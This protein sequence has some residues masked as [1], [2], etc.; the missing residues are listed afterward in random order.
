MPIAAALPAI[1]PAVG[2]ILGGIFG[3][4]SNAINGTTQ[5]QT[6]GANIL[7]NQAAQQATAAG[8]GNDFALEQA[9][10]AR[11]L[12]GGANTDF[13]NANNYLTQAS[14]TLQQPANYYSNILSG[15]RAAMMDA[16][17]PEIQNINANFNQAQRQAGQYAPMGGGR[18]NLLAQLPLQRA[19]AVG[20][21][22]Q[23]IRPQAAQGLLGVGNAQAN[24]GGLQGNIAA[25]QGNIGA[26]LSTNTLS[27]LLSFGSGGTQTGAAL[28]NLGL[29]QSEQQNRAG[30]Q[31]G[32][33]IQN[34]L[35]SIP[36]ANIFKGGSS[37]GSGWSEMAPGDY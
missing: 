4:K 5:A 29:N 24:L 19:G 1:I 8:R 31:F 14:S 15:N 27:N 11:G 26:G 25:Q 33:G 34:I 21:L 7:N 36:W 10:Q 30:A 13:A 32:G 18:A 35:G 16:A 6:Q 28:A 23:T 2:G 9:T 20:N 17:S 3:G 12:L 37:G 22:F